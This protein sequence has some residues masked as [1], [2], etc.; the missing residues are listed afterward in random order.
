MVR[1]G[2]KTGAEMMDLMEGN[3]Q[4]WW[5]PSPGSIYPLLKS[6]T[7]EGVLSRSSDGKY[8]L[9]KMGK[10]EIEL[11]FP[12]MGRHLSSP[13][14]VEGMLEEISYQIAY[15]EDLALTKDDKLTEQRA[16]IQELSERLAKVCGK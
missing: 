14:S 10:E 6:M 7:E 16:K 5:R 3:L 1:E 8:S 4:G 15:L 11:P 9:T 2:P 12:W 13:R